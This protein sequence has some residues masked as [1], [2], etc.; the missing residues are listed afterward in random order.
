M[1]ASESS[2][3][4]RQEATSGSTRPPDGVP[5]AE[6]KEIHIT[7][8]LL[9][10]A[11]ASPSKRQKSSKPQD[12]GEV[13]DELLLQSDNDDNGAF[14]SMSQPNPQKF[15]QWNPEIGHVWSSFQLPATSNVDEILHDEWQ[16]RYPGTPYHL[17]SKNQA[18]EP[19]PAQTLVNVNRKRTKSDPA[20][21]L[22]DFSTSLKLFDASLRYMICDKTFRISA[23]IKLQ[24][25][26]TG[27]K[28]AAICPVLF[29]PGYLQ[30]R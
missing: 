17:S 12:S 27:P 24:N 28:L 5:H 2:T 8:T 20:F 10:M 13:E 22:P 23:G 7:W 9:R 3:A 18:V 11:A 30:V 6:L 29:S 19:H 26:S 1:E 14:V 16:V 4:L 15:S 21:E 25:R